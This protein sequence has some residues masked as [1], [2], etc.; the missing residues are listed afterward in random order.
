M[1]V[2]PFRKQ[3]CVSDLDPTRETIRNIVITTLRCRH[4]VA[5]LAVSQHY[6][7]ALAYC[8]AREAPDFRNERAMIDWLVARLEREQF[9]LWED[10]MDGSADMVA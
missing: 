5:N 1:T 2:L 6:L 10:A 3:K 4:V 8:I 7:P 9:S